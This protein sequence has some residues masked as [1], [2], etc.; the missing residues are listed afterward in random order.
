[1]SVVPTVPAGWLTFAEGVVY[2]H[3]DQPVRVWGIGVTDDQQI[4]G[5]IMKLGGSAFLWSIV[6]FLF[7][8]RFGAGFD[9]DNTY[10]RGHARR[11]GRRHGR[12]ELTYEQVT[13]AFARSPAAR[14]TGRVAARVTVRA[15]RPRRRGRPTTVPGDEPAPAERVAQHVG[16]RA[17]R[18]Q[19]GDR[20]QR[21]GQLGERDHHA[22]EQQQDEVEAVLRGEVDLAA[23]PAGEREADAGERDGARAPRP[24]CASAQSASSGRQSERDAR[25][26]RAPR[27]GPARRAATPT[28]LATIR[29]PRP[30]GVAPSRLSTW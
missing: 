17:G 15:T 26:G 18:E 19:P 4:A 7:F 27:T 30:S 10:V 1:M 9:E 21:P 2:K 5:V 13:E 3:Y 12:D 14:R 8:K 11:A 16:Q 24:R 29:R 28:I 25:P 23:Q 22:A 6:I 20:P